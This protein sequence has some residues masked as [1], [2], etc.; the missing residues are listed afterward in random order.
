MPLADREKWD[1]LHASATEQGRAPAWLEPFSKLLPT[2]GAALDVAAG[3]G[4]MARWAA[5][6]GLS[7]LAVDISPVGLAKIAHPR[8][9]TLERDLELIR[10]CPQDRS[11][12]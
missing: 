6:R 5:E 2:R 1:A 7:V 12:S 11:R 4:R 10:A 8:V 9:Q 3:S